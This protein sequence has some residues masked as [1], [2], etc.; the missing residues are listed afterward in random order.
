MKENG[1]RAA[2]DILYK[3]EG[4]R[5]EKDWNYEQK[6]GREY[7]R[8]H[9]RKKD[10]GERILSEELKSIQRELFA[11]PLFLAAIIVILMILTASAC[12]Y[13]DRDGTIYS[14]ADERRLSVYGIVVGRECSVNGYRI[15]MDHL[16]FGL[17]QKEASSVYRELSD[18]MNRVVSPGDR[19][20]VFLSNGK[21]KTT[22]MYGEGEEA[23]FWTNSASSI[24]Q[25]QLFDSIQIGD[26]VCFRGKCTQPERA[27]NPGQFDSRRYYL[28]KKIILKMSE[29]QG[30]VLLR[31]A[32]TGL[33]GLKRLYSNALADMRIG[34]QTGLLSV[35]GR[36]DSAL[37]AAF[38]MSDKSGMDSSD[39]MLYKDT[40]LTWLLS[41]SSLHISIL[42]M[43]LY[44]FLRKRGISFL[45]SS[46][47]ALFMV[48][49]YA[50]LSG[51]SVSSQRALVTYAFWLGAQ[52][53][54]R[55]ADTLSSLSGA[56]LFILTRQ[57]YALWDSSFLISF[58]CILSME[59]LTPAVERV[60]KPGFSFFRKICA[61]ISIR[62]GV[63]PVSLWFFYQTTPYAFVV[64][65]IVLPLMSLLLGFAILG[66]IAGYALTK[67]GAA[68]F[69]YTGKCFAYPCHLLILIIEIISR[70]VQAVPGSVLIIGRPAAWQVFLYYAALIFFSIKIRRLNS[71][72][73]HPSSRFPAHRFYVSQSA[74]GPVLNRGKPF[75]AIIK[76]KVYF[77]FEKIC[78]VRGLTRTRLTV[79]LLYLMLTT[80]LCA[81]GYPEFQFLCLDV[82]QGSCN[83][84]RH[85]KSVYLFDAGSSSVQDVWKYRI[86]STLKY[87]G[88]SRIDIVFLSHGD[89][90]HINGIEQ[91][92][93]LYRC[94]VAGENVA[95]VTIEKI[96]L[97]ELPEVDAR[98]APIMDGAGENMI[99]VQ[100]ISEGDRI[101]QN[102]LICS[103]L[104][105][106]RS[107][108]TGH[109]NEDCIVLMISY[110][111]LEI[112]LMA[113]LEKEGEELFVES[114]LAGEKKGKRI[115]VAGHHGSKN[116]TSD[117]FLQQVK[118]D[119]CLI[120]CGK[121]NR[122]GHPA[123][124]F[125]QRL[126]EAGIPYRRTDRDGAINISYGK[127]SIV[128]NL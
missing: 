90:D 86:D 88:I 18:R 4:Y 127:S 124:D 105:P 108:I 80:M 45:L 81:R 27:A 109:S 107:R 49:S 96:L 33:A 101:V 41:V 112:L 93:D 79:G 51:Y 5:R 121:N 98:L 10:S 40:G 118:P 15:I 65:L 87:Y 53:F 128:H 25:S 111:E 14:A 9:N 91:M 8:N 34:M 52:I 30:E 82:G 70:G 12:G 23:S 84:I 54:G 61:S 56:A 67:T 72:F 48:N 64:H 17:R 36:K 11:R 102:D 97:P 60:L 13:L 16:Q 46:A 85:G 32:M 20:Q 122:Y 115:L 38:T 95:D 113:D 73:F 99:P 26:H 19:I 57:P 35:F 66:S 100:C 1:R 47:A 68:V 55:T 110:K 104:N 29:A 116:A 117:A 37:I 24:D 31:P 6:Y 76:Q 7:D 74:D 83:L 39:Q 78:N 63:L 69:L 92:M 44:R 21:N 71:S 2:V 120:S 28:A 125:L 42:G 22:N 58:L 3:R 126:E 77:L 43:F 59:Y 103:V 119:V 106:S 114:C 89:M 62:I 50:M 123:P 75:P 94:N